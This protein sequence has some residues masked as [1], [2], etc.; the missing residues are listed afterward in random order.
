MKITKEKLQQ[1]IKEEYQLQRPQRKSCPS[2]M[3][4]PNNLV[5]IQLERYET[6]TLEL[7][8]PTSIE[9]NHQGLY[10]GRQQ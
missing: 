5:Q 2:Y 6:R 3:E 10:V 4:G 7:D 1:I 8:E 9:V